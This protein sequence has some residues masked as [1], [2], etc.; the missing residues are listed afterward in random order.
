[1]LEQSSPWARIGGSVIHPR[2]AALGVP[3]EVRGPSGI[4]NTSWDRLPAFCMWDLL[5]CVLCRCRTFY[6]YSGL[7]AP[8]IVALLTTAMPPQGFSGSQG[9]D[10]DYHWTGYEQYGGGGADLRP[11][12]QQYTQMAAPEAAAWGLQQQQ[13][14]QWYDP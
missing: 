1:M 12:F 14:P 5:F 9:S 7:S 4:V 10:G 8:D 2:L 13:Q 11:P 3:S 6:S